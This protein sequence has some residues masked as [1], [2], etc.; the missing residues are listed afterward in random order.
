M[1]GQPAIV[2]L[3]WVLVA[4]AVAGDVLLWMVASG[5]SAAEEDPWVSAA[6]A[7]AGVAVAGALGLLAAQRVRAE[8]EGNAHRSAGVEF[9]NAASDLNYHLTTSPEAGGESG[10]REDGLKAAGR[11]AAARNILE[12]WTAGQGDVWTLAQD[13]DASMETARFSEARQA[14]LRRLGRPAEERSSIL[15]REGS[16]G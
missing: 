6:S 5:K 10:W 8:E 12:A 7:M 11:H 9:A 14:L 13:V 3:G 2:R 15:A 4:V 16:G 1:R